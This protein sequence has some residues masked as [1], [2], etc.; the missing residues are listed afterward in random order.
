MDQERS[1]RIRLTLKDLD[2]ISGFDIDYEC[3]PRR[4][5]DDGMIEM[6]AIASESTVAKL[7]R[8]QK[9]ELFVE[10]VGD[11][12]AEAEEA[13]KLVSR[14]NRYADGSVPIGQGTRRL[15]RGRFRP[16]YAARMFR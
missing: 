1:Y 10:V 4:R 3:M 7:Q 12:T 8:S 2:A 9:R 14:S 6:E 16:R 15:R 13:M 11:R 5:R